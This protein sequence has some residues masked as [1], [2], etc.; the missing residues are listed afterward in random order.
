MVLPT[1]QCREATVTNAVKAA[2]NGIS[3]CAPQ[4]SGIPTTINV[5]AGELTI[6]LAFINQVKVAFCYIFGILTQIQSHMRT[7]GAA[8]IDAE[9][10]LGSGGTATLAG[11]DT[12]SVLTLNSGT[13]AAS[14]LLATVNFTT[15]YSTFGSPIV[16]GA[17][18]N[19]NSLN[20]LRAVPLT[21]GAGCEIWGNPNDGT[22]YLINLVMLG[23][24]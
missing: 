10:D 3:A 23:G 16:S 12:A 19:L 8:T 15:P 14:G 11:N 2:V 21:N 13:G 20:G 1:Y 22:T 5:C 7:P 6:W 18:G 4:G 17:A 24:T 9:T